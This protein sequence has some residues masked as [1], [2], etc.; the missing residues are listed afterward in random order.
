MVAASL[1]Q[2]IGSHALR[3]AEPREPNLAV[4]GSNF[5]MA[6]L[7]T[8]HSREGLRHKSIVHVPL[9]TCGARLYTS[10]PAVDLSA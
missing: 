2:H 5:G 1:P 10:P 9:C 4:G 6:V 3:S 8:P 7:A